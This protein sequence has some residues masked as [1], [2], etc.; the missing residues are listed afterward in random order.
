MKKYIGIIGFILLSL[1]LHSMLIA[2][3]HIVDSQAEFDNALVN[4]APGDSIIWEC[5]VYEDIYMHINKSNLTIMA[6]VP[7]AVI[8]TDTSYV[9]ITRDYITLTGFQFLDGNIR[10][11]DVIKTTGSHN[12][13]SHLNIKNYIS[14]KYLVIQAACQFNRVTY[15]NF[16]NRLNLDDINILSILV[17]SVKLGYH[18]ISNCS[19]KNFAGTGGDMG[20]EPIRIGVSSQSTFISRSIVEYCYFTQ[21]NGDREIISNKA[22]QNVFRYNTFENNPVGELTLRHGDKGIVYGNF[23]INGIGGVRIKEGQGHLVFNNYFSGLSATSINLQNFDYDPLDSIVIAYNTFVHSARTA[24]GGIGN[25]KPEHI[26]FANNIFCHPTGSL[27]SA[28]TGNEQWLGNIS[29][30]S[31][32]MTR[33]VGILEIDPELEVNSEGYYGL[34]GNSPAID[35][36]QSGYPAFPEYPGL[37]YDSEI[38]FDIMMQ[39]RAPEITLKDIGCSEYPQNVLIRPIANE[40]NT[41]PSYLRN[42][43]VV[44]LRINIEGMGDVLLDPPSGSYEL[45]TVV[46]L[47]A[48]PSTDYLFGSWSGDLN[49]GSSPDSIVMTCHKEITAHF[50]YSGTSGTGRENAQNETLIN[51]FLNPVTEEISVAV[52]I[53][54]R[55]RIELALFDVFGRRVKTFKHASVLPGDHHISRKIPDLPSGVYLLHV[56]I[57]GSNAEQI[58]VVKV[59]KE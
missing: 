54:N 39:A 44:N 8:F 1:G 49:S 30:G 58:R 12:D 26:T 6:E 59:L 2:S 7:G 23:F 40:N 22:T 15:C 36:A 33:P 21:C 35:A 20:I 28:P 53:D 4:A 27:F 52:H 14:N 16:E 43:E 41:G 10:T 38:D 46:M 11:K 19:F 37:D 47:T 29:C 34:S 50:I 17:D 31:L 5:G 57:R 18:V 3:V 9:T 55:A 48:I 32:G 25:Y 56:R 51:A 45:G 13:F 42:T 24:L